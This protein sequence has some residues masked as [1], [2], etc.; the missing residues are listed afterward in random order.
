MWWWRYINRSVKK[1]KYVDRYIDGSIH[2]YMFR[3]TRHHPHNQTR[4]RSQPQTRRE[5]P[6]RKT[7]TK[8][9]LPHTRRKPPTTNKKNAQKGKKA[10]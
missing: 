5:P 8:P 7:R 10:T 1:A 4:R 3:H 2:I 9:P 6:L